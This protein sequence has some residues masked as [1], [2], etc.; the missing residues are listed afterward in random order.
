MENPFGTAGDK[1]Q[2]E[3]AFTELPLGK[4][5]LARTSDRGG[6]V[7]QIKESR[8]GVPFLFKTG[9]YVIGGDGESVKPNMYGKYCFFQAYLRPNY[10]DQGGPQ[11]QED[12]DSLSGRLTGFMN[13]CL[14][15]SIKDPA[16][17]WTNTMSQ[18]VA[19]ANELTDSADPDTKLTPTMFEVEGTDLRDNAAYMGYVFALLL[20]TSPRNAIVNLKIDKGA[21]G[22]RNDVVVQTAK[23]ATVKN[24]TG[25]DGKTIEAF[26]SREGEVFDL[27]PNPA[28]GEEGDAANF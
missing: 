18:L 3:Q 22:D 25:R 17:R 11:S 28:E 5:F 26:E 15:S 6:A 7:P 27:Y 1:P 24:A 13:A 12:Y 2:T 4:W 14:S 10:K 20:R 21:K 23:D 16:A 8:E 9:L 19:Y